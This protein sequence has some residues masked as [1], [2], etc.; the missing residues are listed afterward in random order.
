MRRRSID[1][2]LLACLVALPC[3]AQPPEAPPADAAATQPVYL[4]R[5]LQ[6]AIDAVYR[7]VGVEVNVRYRGAGSGRNILERSGRLIRRTVG[8]LVLRSAGRTVRI[9]ADEIIRIRYEAVLDS[10]FGGDNEGG[11][12]ALAAFALLTAGVNVNEPHLAALLSTLSTHPLP[13]T[14]GRSLRAA[15]WAYCF[16]LAGDPLERARYRRLLNDDV[17]WLLTSS[18]R[19]AAYGYTRPK[20]RRTG[21][22][23]NSL[24]Q[25]AHL[26]MAVADDASAEIP[27]NFWAAVERHWLGSQQP[28]GGWKYEDI[29]P[30][31]KPSMTVAGANSLY[32]VLDHRY[33]RM[34][35]RYVRFKGARPPS[36]F[37]QRRSEIYD[38]IAR[39]DGYLAQHPPP[40]QDYGGYNLFGLERLGV[41]SGN[42]FVGGRDWY[43]FHLPA[44]EGVRT[45]ADITADCFALIF[46]VYGRA[47]VWIQELVWSVDPARSHPYGRDLHFATRFINQA[48][49]RKLRW[50]NVPE[51]S[52]G[53]NTL[54]D[55]P[56][57][58]ISGP[59][60]LMLTAKMQEDIRRY[61]DRGGAVI[62]HADFGSD[63]FTRT[64]RKMFE[65][66]F[67]DRGWKFRTL[68]ADHP[69]Y[70]CHYGRASEWRDRPPLLGMGGADSSSP[71]PDERR[72]DAA[73]PP[74][75]K[76]D[77]ATVPPVIRGDAGGFVRGEPDDSGLS[78][79]GF[80]IA[81]PP[82]TQ[83]TSK[84]PDRSTGRLPGSSRRRR[85]ST[86]AWSPV[87]RDRI[88]LIPVDLAGAWH[89][90]R[91][92]AERDLFE[93]AVN[94]RVY[95]A[96]PYEDLPFRPQPVAARP[97]ARP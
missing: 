86:E 30:T 27:S 96:P 93:L 33:T 97:P 75:L 4:E 2:V 36:R 39:A 80:A 92:R 71:A 37:V 16:E 69:V 50:Q 60:Q 79:S 78:P 95:L 84:P 29:E 5:E 8:E 57:L 12:H 55:A 90:N 19:D 45:G 9:A 83:P 35:P 3:R 22:T 89:Q 46:L 56:V 23:D 77:S 49:E 13:G 18:L 11:A 32:L 62:L 41:T 25:F 53:L 74:A 65:R 51:A 38:A 1:A 76:G 59:R 52:A 31:S 7:G 82:A 20:D 94:L 14:Y 48:L 17:Q 70:R 88:I 85:A 63:D 72:G 58:Y 81:R 66:I 61:V 67:A 73:V 47:P 43:R 10:H 42:A 15:V 6:R 40:I 54:L 44:V 28:D 24:T 64:A 87:G 91:T 34:E 26:G 68:P 21:R